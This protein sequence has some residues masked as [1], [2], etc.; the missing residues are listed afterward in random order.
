MSELAIR[1]NNIS[2]QFHIGGPKKKYPTLRDQIATQLTAPFRRAR[3]L[4]SGQATGAAELDETIWALKDVSFDVKHG[5]VLGI[6]GRNGAGK[7]TLLKVISRITEPTGGFIDLYGRVGSLLEVG[8]GFHME[9][10]GRENIYLNGSILGMKRTEIERKF[11]EIVDFSEVEKFIDTPVKHYSSGMLVRLAFSV[12]AHLDP[13]ILIVDEVLAVGDAA[14]QK[15]CLNKMEDVGHEGRTVFFVSHNMPTIMR[16]CQRVIL[17]EEG[18]V[19]QDGLPHQ[20]VSTYLNAGVATTAAYE[21]DDPENAPGG[22]VARLRA[23]RIRGADGEISEVIKITQPLT[24]EMEY[25]VLKPGYVLLPHYDMQNDQSDHVM[26][27]LDRD[28]EWIRRPRPVGRYH[29][30]V[31]IPGN[32]LAEGT[33]Y[34]TASL[35]TLSPTSKLQFQERDTVAFQVVDTFDGNSVRGDWTG[36]IGGAVRP[37]FKWNTEFVPSEIAEKV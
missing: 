14:F 1:I 18:K 24:I 28:P 8:T 2:K 23:I 11:D 22:D 29:S 35:V 31:E 9:L 7:S 30:V 34:I 20:V 12:A 17:L 3:K 32:F 21:W 33:M 16:L 10:T 25:D 26:K 4:L 19:V 5:E 27:V 37:L 36:P 13:E 6:I 15:K